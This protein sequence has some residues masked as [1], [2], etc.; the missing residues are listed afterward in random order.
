MVF[1]VRKSWTA[2]LRFC[3]KTSAW[4]VLILQVFMHPACM[5]NQ[6]PIIKNHFNNDMHLTLVKRTAKYAI[7]WKHS[8]HK[9]S[10]VI[11]PHDT[12]NR[13]YP[14]IHPLPTITLSD[15]YFTL[16]PWRTV[17]YMLHWP[18][19]TVV[20]VGKW[21]EMET[22]IYGAAGIYGNTVTNVKKQYKNQSWSVQTYWISLNLLSKE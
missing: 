5:E 11:C 17:S 19:A 6:S 1:I 20:L 18:K 9:D 8:K 15:W 7:H 21:L 2:I 16:K 14:Q 3:R 22:L 4:Q 12:K 10:R 13:R